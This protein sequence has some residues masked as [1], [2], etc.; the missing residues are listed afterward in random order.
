MNGV[1]AKVDPPW[2][3]AGEVRRVL[4]ALEADGSP[5]R[6][7]GGCVRDAL[8]R[9]DLDPSD[10]DLATGER[11]ERVMELLAAAR[12]RA[13]PTGLAH[14]TVTAL[15]GGRQLEITTLRRDVATDGRHAEV[16]FTRDFD[17]DAARRDFTINAM[18][19]DDE[20]RLHD[21]MGGRADLAAGRVRF[22]GDARRRIAEDYLRILRFF[23]FHARYGRGPADAAA[24][25][26]CTELAHG[27][28]RLSGERVR[29]ELW[30]ILAGPEVA[31]TLRLMRSTGVLDRAVSALASVDALERLVACFPEADPLLRLAAL[32]REAPGAEAVRLV[33]RL[34]LAN[35]ERDRLMALVATSLPDLAGGLPLMRQAIYDLGPGLFGD[36]VRLGAGCEERARAALDLAGSWQPPR[37]P[38]RGDDL[39]ARGVASGPALGRLL[40][41]VERDWRHSDFALDREACLA[42]LDR[43]LAQTGP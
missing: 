17:A 10:L 40:A 1:L 32:I 22:V 25:A 42:R 9:P 28:D 11:P 33:D 7:V 36:L 13:I 27:I 15:A 8:I 29:Q 26:A 16:E 30:R 37:F 41:A 31:P 24:L 43:L 2:L 3:R 35:A 38:L 14:G 23:R 5:A 39:L 18:S 19:C 12:I 21:P 6:F 34:K 20:G 4:A